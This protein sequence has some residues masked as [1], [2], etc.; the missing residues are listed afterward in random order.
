MRVATAGPI[1]RCLT[2]ADMFIMEADD[3]FAEIFGQSSHELSALSV[4]D[5]THPD[6]RS[7]NLEQ[8]NRLRTAGEAFQITKR[9]L[10]PDRDS[11]WVRNDVSRLEGAGAKQMLMATVSVVAPPKEAVDRSLWVTARKVQARRQV[12]A[13]AF[14]EQIE[15]EPALHMLL[16][17]FVSEVEHQLPTVSSV[18][19]SSLVPMATALR[20]Q[21]KLIDV[22]MV[23]KRPDADDRR[24]AT[25]HLT[26]EGQQTVVLYLESIQRAEERAARDCRRKLDRGGG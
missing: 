17:L 26:E 2:N 15:S 20:H 13:T 9:Y 3:R 19:A 1:A 11:L 5:L 10:R 8:L 24:R 23:E 7:C 12:R 18:G 6:D 4:I 21:A 16:D 25:M 22:G 14:R